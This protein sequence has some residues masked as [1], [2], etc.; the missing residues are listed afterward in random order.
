MKIIILLLCIFV[1]LSTQNEGPDKYIQIFA[2]CG[3][4]NN[5]TPEQAEEIKNMTFPNAPNVKCFFKCSMVKMNTMNADTNETDYDLL[6]K[7][8]MDGTTVET[9]TEI[10]NACKNINNDDGCEL[11]YEFSMCCM[12]NSPKST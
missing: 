4:E 5:I 2:E 1:A 6:I 10:V 8:E 12:K 3:K 11:A 9:R 7:M